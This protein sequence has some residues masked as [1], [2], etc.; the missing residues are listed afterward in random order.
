MSSQPTE[1]QGPTGPTGSAGQGQAHPFSQD[2]TMS[3]TSDPTYPTPPMAE[4]IEQQLRAQHASITQLQQGF[5]GL[6]ASVEHHISA[7]M[8]AFNRL[9]G[10]SIATIAPRAPE[11][12]TS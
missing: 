7:L 5:S 11:G 1:G 4:Q 3:F 10:P 6:Q 9:Q 2:S 8:E 12:P